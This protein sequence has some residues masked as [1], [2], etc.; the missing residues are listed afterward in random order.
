LLVKAADAGEYAR[1]EAS[2]GNGMSISA[3]TEFELAVPPG[4]T[5]PKPSEVAGYLARH[6]DLA[7]I[8]PRAC[9]AA[10]ERVGRAAQLSLEL[11]R[12]PESDDEYLTLYVRQ[13]AYAPDLLDRIE[14]LSADLC[15]E[16]PDAA[17]LL[18]ITTDFQPPRRP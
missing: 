6:A 5:V 12:D 9:G 10:L 8:V 15:P 7:E 4:I 18:L 14:A 13:W 16:A 11:F 3:E 17:G 2:G 1:S